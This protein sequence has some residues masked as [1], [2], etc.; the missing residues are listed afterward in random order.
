MT[1]IELLAPAKNL[2]CGIAAIDHGADAV[3]IGAKRFGARAAAGNS[4]ED[5]AELCRY[6]HLFGAKAYV[7]VNTIIYDEELTE[8]RQLMKEL[9]AVGVDAFLIQD[10]GL[11][12]HHSSPITHHHLL[13][14]SQGGVGR[15]SVLHA[16]TQTDNR[17]VEKVRWLR[18]LGF[19]RVVL[20][21]ELS[22]EDIRAIH[23]AVPDVE[24]EVFVHGALC[25]SYSGVCYASQY[26]FKRSA[27]RGECA[28][29][30]RMKFDLKDATGQTIEHQRHLL[31]LR[32]MCRINDLEAL[33]DAGAVSLKIEG[34]LKDV[35]YV[36]NVV[37]AYSQRLNEI[38]AKHPDRYQRASVGRCTYTFTPDLKKTFNRGF[39]DYFLHTT[40]SSSGELKG[41]QPDIVSFDTPKA[42]GEYVGKVKEIR[43]RMFTV[44]G[45]ASFANGDGLCFFNDDHE[46]EGFR[47]NR[48]EGNHLYPLQMP[49]S[50]RPGMGLYRN[51]DVVFEK[52]MAGKTAERKIPVRM[53]YEAIEN[54]FRLTT[55]IIGSSLTGERTVIGTALKGEATV[56]FEHQL[57]T[58]P[59]ASNIRQQLSKLG[60]TPFVLEDLEIAGDADRFFI[61]NSL[62]TQLRREGLPQGKQK[63]L[64]KL[65]KL[66][67]LEKLEELEK[68]D[69]LEELV[70]LE[71]QET[72]AVPKTSVET[73][74][75]YLYNIANKDARAFYEKQGLK[76]LQPAF[77]LSTKNEHPSNSYHP[78]PNTHH[79]SPITHH[80]SF[81]LKGESEG[82]LLMQCRHCLRFSL[83]YCVKNGGKK[84]Y[85]KE[86]LSLVLADGRRFELQ[87]DCKHCQMNVYG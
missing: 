79:P 56:S 9:D 83:G 29:F 65:D 31:S 46:L 58:R 55:T 17:T 35:P 48:A 87:F 36:K 54:G 84:P 63:E 38:I 82:A 41:R 45:T 21:R 10:L 64:V 24:L 77:E 4:V 47:V 20:A 71:N 5:I 39:T 28:Q 33:L 80:H 43:G 52:L 25:V 57:A 18:S 15:V 69:K 61:P 86:P 13:P 66:V 12:T 78:S 14:P 1:S 23:V 53:R 32:D 19:K 2:A 67:E 50:L 68:L 75:P 3:Y 37:A 59:Q 8:T 74:Y 44:A 7:T 81:P 30:C 16:S 34:R 62:L 70:T 49:R 51:Q 85:W 76:N 22:L 40:H 11:L 42:M 73:Q 60:D 6:A 27:N 26:C 72:P